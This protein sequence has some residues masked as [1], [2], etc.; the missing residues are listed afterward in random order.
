MACRVEDHEL[1]KVMYLY[2][3][4]QQAVRDAGY[5]A[6]GIPTERFEVKPHSSGLG[7]FIH[8]KET[9]RIFDVD[10]RVH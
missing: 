6:R 1:G 8:D 10:G 3:E 9:G 4:Q 7:W 2:T 5:M